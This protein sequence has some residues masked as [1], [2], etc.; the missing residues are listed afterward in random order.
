MIATITIMPIRRN[1]ALKSTNSE[2]VS[3]RILSETL[4][5]TRSIPA[6]KAISTRLSFE[7]IIKMK[8]TIK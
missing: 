1:I 7:N 4:R 8:A 3:M 5:A 2:M 6:V